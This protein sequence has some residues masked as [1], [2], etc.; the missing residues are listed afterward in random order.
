M[1]NPFS[2]TELLQGQ[3][4]YSSVEKSG[5]VGGAVGNDVNSEVDAYNKK[6]DS[7][8][9]QN[10]G[11]VTVQSGLG[12]TLGAHP[13]AATQS[14]LK[15]M[16]D[17]SVQRIGALKSEMQNHIDAANS[18]ASKAADGG[19]G[20]KIHSALASHH[21]DEAQKTADKIAGEQKSLSE[22]TNDQN[23]R[24]SVPASR[25]ARSAMAGVSVPK[26]TGTVGGQPGHP[27]Y[28]NQHT[29]A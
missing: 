16:H 21:A 17:S 19:L 5:A 15:N 1:S 7:Y 18:H 29:S 25:E 2:T 20:S 22:V 27:F 12:A 8:L 4:I 3:G 10:P 28:G 24:F 14:E 9:A 23:K 6:T 13:R 11:A 26:G